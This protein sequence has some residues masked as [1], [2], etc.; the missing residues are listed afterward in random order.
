[1]LFYYMILVFT[2]CFRC[3]AYAK[4]I[5]QTHTNIYT[6]IRSFIHS[7]HFIHRKIL[8][9]KLYNNNNEWRRSTNGL[10]FIYWFFLSLSLYLSVYFLI[11]IGFFLHH[12]WL[13]SAVK[14]RRKNNRKNH[15]VHIRLE[16]TEKREQYSN[17]RTKISRKEKQIAIY[18]YYKIYRCVY[19]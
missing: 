2:F 8:H 3:S 14:I 13:L 7:L 18:C 6:Y 9:A 11:Q 5:T 15:L 12:S 4:P 17:K 16:Q 19:V 10:F 1:M